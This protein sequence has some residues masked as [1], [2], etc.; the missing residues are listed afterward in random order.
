MVFF[1]NRHTLKMKFWKCEKDNQLYNKVCLH[2]KL[3]S[4][5][6]YVTLV[7]GVSLINEI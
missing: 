3:N 7:L 4:T 1:R 5:P 2:E 6:I